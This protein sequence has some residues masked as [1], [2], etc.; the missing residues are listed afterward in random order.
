MRNAGLSQKVKGDERQNY[1]FTLKVFIS[2]WEPDLVQEAVEKSELSRVVTHTHTHTYTDANTHAHT[3]LAEI[4]VTSVD[5]LI[6]SFPQ[7]PE[8][9]LLS[10]LKPVWT[11]VE[12]LARSGLA[13]VVGTADVIMPQL[14]E[15]YDWATIKPTVNQV[16]L[17]HCCTMPEV[18]VSCN[19][20]AMQHV[21]VVQLMFLFVCYSLLFRIWLSFRSST[22]SP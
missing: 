2:H 10:K 19:L 22:R 21:C 12:E 3:A 1:I 13:S 18:C 20:C 5:T 4:G 7:C 16:N 14:K 17:A 11:R 6:L 15:L 9:E 8:E